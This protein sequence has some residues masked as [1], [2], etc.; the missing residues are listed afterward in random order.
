MTSPFPGM[1]P[2]LVTRWSNV[3]VMTMSIM[4]TL[5]KRLLPPGLEARPEE[6]VRIEAMAG[7]RLKGFRADV[8]VVDSRRH[9]EL[10]STGTTSA[11]AEPIVVEFHRGPIITR[12][13]EIVDTRNGDRVVTAIEVLSPW[14]KLSGR[15]NR[16]Y[17]RKLRAYDDGG[18]NWVE[19]DLL[20]SPRS[21]LDLTWDDLPPDRRGAYLVVVH[22]A[23]KDKLMAYPIGLRDRLP[24]I[25]VPLREGDAPVSLDMQHVLDRVYE[26]G[27]FE[28]I[29]Y[30]EPCDPPL[31]PADAEW[32]ASLVAARGSA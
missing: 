32:S 1:D 14:D 15:L 18:A 2:Y 3:H 23:G 28:S 26:D 4:A 31:S 19:I 22:H 30:S 11:V 17:R 20:R 7:E 5:L 13:I 12:N 16:D 24:V 9:A 25:G 29:D 21:R 6:S 10:R 27:P 8:A